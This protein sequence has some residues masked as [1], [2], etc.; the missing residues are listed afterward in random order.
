MYHIALVVHITGLAMMAGTTLSDYV[1]TKQFWK[2]YAIDKSRGLAINGAMSKFPMF[3][4]LGIILLILS[5]VTM[6]GLTHGLF[7]E[8]IWFRIKF[9]LVIIIIL[10]GVAVGRRLTMKLSKFL[11]EEKPGE[12]IAEQLLKVK[13][14]M[15]R[16][17][18]SQ[19]VLFIIVFVLSV[20]KFN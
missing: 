3:F 15:N 7:G 14:N 11:S 19:I 6:M 16:F 2:Q 1:I 20:F 4:G 12:N 5:G 8:Q 10:N 9:G 13:T 17:H 18:I